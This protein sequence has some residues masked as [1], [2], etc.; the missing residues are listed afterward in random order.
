L[1]PAHPR[2][3]QLNAD[4]RGLRRSIR[5]EVGKVVQSLEKAYRAAQIRVDDVARQLSAVKAKVVD[6][7]GDDAQVRV[8][9][10]QARS[11]RSELRR[12]RRQLEDNKTLVATKSVPIEAQII[13]AARPSTIV[14]FPK[15]APISALVMAAAFMLGMMGS[16][17]RALISGGSGPVET[18]APRGAASRG[19]D[20]IDDADAPAPS[21]ASP[22]TGRSA[23]AGAVAGAAAVPAAAKRVSSAA[24]GTAAASRARLSAGPASFAD[25]DTDQGDAA[26]LGHEDANPMLVDIASHL[27]DRA[28]NG[29]GYR[30][31][32][33]GDEH[34]VNPVSEAVEIATLIAAGGHQVV[35]IDCSSDG[36]GLFDGADDAAGFSDLVLG[37][38]TF[39]QVITNLDGS[40]AH[41]VACGSA[42]EETHDPD[43][44]NLVLDALDE[45][46]DHIVVVGDYAASRALF[47]LIQGRFDAGITVTDA[48]RRTSV[49]E[50]SENS[51]LGFEVTDIDVIHY[52]RSA[53]SA[54]STR[55]L[56]LGGAEAGALS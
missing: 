39:D 48:R 47:E 32:V 23:V 30:V 44:A 31:M 36:E 52:E 19:R 12:L 49:L 6:T 53:N 27:I 22:V 14:T 4:L 24:S 41:F 5:G 21:F 16:A 15:K 34:R 2:M 11:K 9:E 10:A 54:F 17:A 46:Y 40:S 18:S 35:L 13:S 20:P 43:S 25:A 29:V 56:E 51:F 3:R 55:R 7:S 1:L 26:Q 28:E 45:A 8:L 37:R 50:D 38:T 42:W 33:V